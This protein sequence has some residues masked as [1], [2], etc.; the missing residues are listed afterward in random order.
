MYGI[1]GNLIAEIQIS[2][3]STNAIGENINTWTKIQTI[4]GWLDYITGETNRTNY[5][6]KIE[7]STHVFVADYIKLDSRITAEK[8]RM[9]INHKIY[10]VTLIDNPMEL[11]AQL[12]IYLKYV[13]G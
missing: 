2:I 11:N 10:D 4:K 3:P 12:E 5:S 8:V 9:V 7:E 1:G 13:G 6:A